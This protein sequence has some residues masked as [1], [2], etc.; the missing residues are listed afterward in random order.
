MK[1]QSFA[2]A[3]SKILSQ[4]RKHWRPQ[5]SSVLL[6][7]LIYSYTK[8]S[9]VKHLASLSN[10]LFNQGTIGQF[11]GVLSVKFDES[12]KFFHAAVRTHPHTHRDHEQ[13]RFQLKLKFS[14]VYSVRKLG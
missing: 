5:L 11:F 7:L 3:K 9:A 10:V 8:R 4:M 13:S 6:N 2:K 1:T 14:H 12:T